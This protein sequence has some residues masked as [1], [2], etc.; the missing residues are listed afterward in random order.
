MAFRDINSMP[1]HMREKARAALAGAASQAAP[2]APLP[3]PVTASAP[4][5]DPRPAD[6]VS[7]HPNRESRRHAQAQWPEFVA[8]VRK[9][10]PTRLEPLTLWLPGLQMYSENAALRGE[11]KREGRNRIKVQGA[12]LQ[13]VQLAIICANPPL[14]RIP[15]RVAIRVYQSGRRR[16]IDPGNLFH[17]P[18][19]DC[20]LE[21]GHGLGIIH[22]DSAKHVESITIGY[23]PDGSDL[24][25]VRIVIIP[26]G[27][28]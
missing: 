23:D 5:L 19:V 4:V 18:V 14:W 8:S 7:P 15:S 11:Q 27:L 25:G 12:A 16:D 2:T 21:R 24:T 9:A 13:E 22:D 6:H 26:G 10:M 17:K 3:V 20:L 1:P 28:A